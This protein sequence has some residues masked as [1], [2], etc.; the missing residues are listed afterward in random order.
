MIQVY[1]QIARSLQAMRNCKAS[2]NDEGLVKHRERIES[3]VINKL[4][5][6]SG[7]DNGV[8]MNFFDSNPNKLVFDF[9]FHHMNDV[10]CYDGWTDHTLTVTP[11]L[12]FGFSMKISGTDRNSIKDY[13]HD[14]FHTALTENAVW[15]E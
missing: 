12:A 9:A 6:G 5:S 8:T 10:G 14:T 3:L 4:P 1:Q 15:T 13:L 7:I 11:D 2:G